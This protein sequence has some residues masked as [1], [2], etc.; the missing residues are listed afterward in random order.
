[1]FLEFSVAFDD[2][3]YAYV[4]FVGYVCVFCAGVSLEVS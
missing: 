4:A 3:V 2:G 1:L